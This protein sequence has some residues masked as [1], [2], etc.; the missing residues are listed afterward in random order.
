M[1]VKVEQSAESSPVDVVK[2]VLAAAL[3]VAGVVAFYWFSE[4]PG[5]LRGLMVAGGLVLGGAVFAFTSKGRAAAEYLSESRFELRKVVW[6]TR[7]ETLRSTGVIAVVVVIISLLLGLI[8]L[9][10][11]NVVRWLLGG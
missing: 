4:W 8:D 7:Q 6:P 11:S 10:V 5:P 3:V 2:Y 9:I 1:N